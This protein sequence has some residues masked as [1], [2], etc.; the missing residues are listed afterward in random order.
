LSISCSSWIQVVMLCVMTPC[1]DVVGYQRIGVSCFLHLQ[2]EVNLAHTL[3]FRSLEWNFVMFM[4][5][6]K[7]YCLNIHNLVLLIISAVIRRWA[8]GWTVGVL[9]FDSRWRLGIFLFAT[10][11]RTAL[12]PPSLLSNG[13]Q[14][15]FPWDKAAGAWGWPLTSI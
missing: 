8:T 14:G 4:H 3:P 13:Y 12:G 5:I 15:L 10:A 2:G 7:K 11:S 9:G 6:S 1:N